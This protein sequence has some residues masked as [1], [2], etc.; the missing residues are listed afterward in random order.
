MT[1]AT[2]STSK[3]TPRKRARAST[4]NEVLKKAYRQDEEPVTP[5]S[6]SDLPTDDVVPG[7]PVRSGTVK[8]EQQQVRPTP[9]SAPGSAGA[10]TPSPSARFGYEKYDSTTNYFI[11]ANKIRD[12][13]YNDRSQEAVLADPKFPELKES[14]ELAGRLAEAIVVRPL[15]SIDDDGFEFEQVIGCKR[16]TACKL[17]SAGFPVEC[18]VQTLTDAEAA[19]LQ[20]AENKGR[21]DPPIWDR[22]CAWA[23]LLDQKVYG[24]VRE[25]AL[26]LGEKHEKT[27][28][29]YVR[30][31][32][33]IMDEPEFRTLPLSQLAQAPLELL[34][35][36]AKGK[37]MTAT[38]RD[39]LVQRIVEIED[40]LAARPERATKML[41]RTIAE[42]NAAKAGAD[43]SAA[44]VDAPKVFQS[45]HGKTLTLTRKNQELRLVV[46]ADV[47]SEVNHD[48]I[49]AMIVSYLREKGLHIKEKS[50]K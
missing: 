36:I 18:S 14:I 26:A 25:L 6:G 44:K 24:S 7:I 10:G 41:E 46:H 3:R 19:A 35:G 45:E 22:G 33:Y 40:E 32:R 31:A 49:E 48:E 34:A 12:W 50:K 13:K 23:K 1:Q 2:D 4:G 16:L 20:A 28:A 11:P 8:P 27:V 37:G 30:F 9:S 5:L 47:A 29:N 38:E 15:P 39:E 42:F 17:I 43:S 21:S